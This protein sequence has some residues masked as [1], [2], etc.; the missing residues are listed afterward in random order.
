MN[1]NALVMTILV[2]ATVSPSIVLAAPDMQPGKWQITSTIEM[3]G[4][5]FAMP[6]STHT[7]C[8]SSEYLVPQTQPENDKCQMIENLIDGDT[9]TWKVKC[10]SKGGTM[11]SQGRIVYHGGS[12]EGTVNTTGSQMPSGMTQK[13]SGKR[14]GDCK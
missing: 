1:K 5:A 10:E 14:I 3:P 11:T 12:F 2:L 8:I 4:M 13:M 7:Q 9:V 6:A